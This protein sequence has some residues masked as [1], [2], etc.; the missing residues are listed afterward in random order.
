M[1]RHL[2]TNP[3][4]SPGCRAEWNFST[5]P[6]SQHHSRRSAFGVAHECWSPRR[7][8]LTVRYDRLVHRHP[9]TLMLAQHH[10]ERLLEEAALLLD[11]ST[12]AAGTGHRHEQWT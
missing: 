2:S 4:P 3:A 9:Y 8:L 10:S 6:H 12:S 11:W 7:R 1:R 5:G